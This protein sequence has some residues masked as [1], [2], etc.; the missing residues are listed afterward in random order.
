MTETVIPTKSS[1]DQQC[2]TFNQEIRKKHIPWYVFGDPDFRRG[3][4]DGRISPSAWRDS[5]QAIRTD[6]LL[7]KEKIR[8]ILAQN[9]KVAQE[10]L[11]LFP[12]LRE[13]IRQKSESLTAD[14]SLMS[15][16][17]AISH[18][19]CPKFKL[20]FA[21]FRTG[22][23]YDEAV[24]KRTMAQ[25][26]LNLYRDRHLID[27]RESEWQVILGKLLAYAGHLDELTER[28]I[29][30]RQSSYCCGF[31]RS[32]SGNSEATTHMKDIIAAS[33]KFSSECTNH[34]GSL[35]NNGGC[36]APL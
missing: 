12:E 13:Q 7:I 36:S 26:S 33:D 23:N 18:L 10:S 32:A 21:F 34:G 15:E 8:N 20:V 28:I 1:I 29:V 25:Y 35:I 6:E 11:H 30:S 17:A 19:K 27:S 31:H 2:F 9:I 24:E 5:L 22:A 16:E 3:R 14:G 4:K